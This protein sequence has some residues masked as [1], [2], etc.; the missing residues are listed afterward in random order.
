MAKGLGH[1]QYDEEMIRI[2]GRRIAYG[3]EIR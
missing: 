1:R 3:D 2:R